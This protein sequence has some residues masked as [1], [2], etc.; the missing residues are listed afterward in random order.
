MQVWLALEEKQI[1]YDCVLIELYNK[2]EWYKELVP[3]T[4]VPAAAFSEDGSVVWESKHILLSL[5]DRFPQAMPLLPIDPADREQ[6]LEF[7]RELEECGLDKTGYALMTGGRMISRSASTDTTTPTPDIAEL[8]AAFV[9]AMDWFEGTALAKHPKGPYLLGEDFSLLD[10]MMI[11][12]MERIGAGLPKFRG[13]DVRNNPKYPNSAAWF[14]AIASRP[15]YQKVC[16][17]DQTLQLLFQRMM[18]LSASAAAASR[19]SAA[20]AAAAATAAFAQTA[21]EAK[22]GSESATP[23]TEE[24]QAAKTEAFEKLQACYGDVVKDVLN[25]SGITRYQSSPYGATTLSF[26]GHK[27][28]VALPVREA[29]EQQVL[30]VLKALLLGSPG[31]KPNTSIAAAFGAVAAAF[32]RNRY[33][34]CGKLAELSPSAAEALKAACTQAVTQ[35]YADG[36]EALPF[37]APEPGSPAAAAAAEA[38]LKVTMNKAAIVDDILSKSGL[39]RPGTSTYGSTYMYVNGHKPSISAAVR[40]AV[41]FH[42]DRLCNMLLVGKAGPKAEER[43]AAA[44]GAAGLAFFRNRASA[45]RD[46]S[47]AATVQFRAACDAVLADMY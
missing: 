41:E 43:E 12:S 45:P 25:L 38:A 10:I 44:V 42:L 26:N 18:G 30:R 7:M 8:E 24:Q 14:A 37:V 13:F 31:S 35:S 20:S 21:A 4:L 40:G 34:D 28:R 1:P 23:P 32:L 3:T 9:K 29:V 36:V 17:D 15:A 47:A 16:S 27:P 5:E 2:P 33:M 39:A 19:S 46:M 6:A 22:S 11:S